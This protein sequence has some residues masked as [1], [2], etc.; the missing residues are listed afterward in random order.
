MNSPENP[1]R[2]YVVHVFAL[3]V[4]A[5]L[6]GFARLPGIPESDRAALASGFK[7]KHFA[8][9]ELGGFPPRFV[10]DVHPSLEHMKGWISTVGASIA[11]NDLDGDG[12]SNDLCYVNVRTNQVLVLPAPGTQDRYDLFDLEPAPL[13][14]DSKTMAPMGC[15]PGDVNEDGL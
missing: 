13:P 7:F 1:L 10:R 11:L 14:Y 2:R 3:A 5:I 6:Y 4:L 9:P 12:L 15:L 8:L